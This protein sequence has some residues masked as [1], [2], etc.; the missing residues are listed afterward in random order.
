MIVPPSEDPKIIWKNQTVESIDLSPEEIQAKAERLE[1]GIRRRT[2]MFFLA[3]GSQV[4]LKLTA[5][6]MGFRQAS[7]YVVANF[8]LIAAA[9]LY[10]PFVFFYE[11]K[12]PV[13]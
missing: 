4:A 8:A 13:S 7:W 2:L 10:F 5:S 12:W 11:E 6:M 1:A 9:V 3:S